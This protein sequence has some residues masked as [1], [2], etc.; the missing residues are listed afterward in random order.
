MAEDIAGTSAWSV[1]K[2]K[3]GPAGQVSLLTYERFERPF[4]ALL[5]SLTI[6]LAN[7]SVTRRSYR[8]RANPPVLHRKELLLDPDDPRQEMFSALTRAL[9]ARGLFQDTR[10]IGTRLGWAARL[11]Q[12][13]VRVIDHRLEDIAPGQPPLV[14]RHR[15]ALSRDGLS[16]PIQALARHG[17]LVPGATLFDY[18]CG[19]GS[20]IEGLVQAGV[21]ASGWDPH[22]A[23]DGAKTPAELVNLGFVLN[24]IENP[25]ERLAVL[26]EA[27]GLARRCLAVAVITQTSAR[28]GSARAFGDGFLTSR[29]TFQKFY[30]QDELRSLLE[31]RLGREAFKVAAGLYFVFQD[32][33]AEQLYLASRQTR[34][35]P[36]AA[37]YV[38]P[39]RDQSRREVLAPALAALWA[40]ILEL[41]R[42]A[43]EDELSIEVV[44]ALRDQDCTLSAA[45]RWA[46]ALDPGAQLE[47][48][49]ARRR[50]DLLVYFA[51]N[52]FNRR[53]DYRQ[54]PPGLQRD[55]KTLFGAYGEAMIQATALLFGLGKPDAVAAACVST[56][57]SGLGALDA[58]GA[59]LFHARLTSRLPPLLR[60][61]VGC[62]GRYHGGLD[63]ADLLKIHARS[64]KLTALFYGD[65]TEPAPRLRR[66]IK[67]DLKSQKILEVDHWDEDQRLVGKAR[68]M[69]DDQPGFAPQARFDAAL[70]GLIGDLPDAVQGAALDALITE[71]GWVR[72][73][74][75]LRPTSC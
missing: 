66:R 40:Q 37:I 67:V 56:A 65:F 38:T 9:E 50:E 69:A 74:Y 20:D 30:A 46:L 47:A 8:T 54:L 7:A 36:S 32:D 12:A 1:A 22:F 25:A 29:G 57:R 42:P 55:V 26:D 27:F 60:V 21:S 59:L 10:S 28:L 44:D 39:R 72:Q 24:V 62:A 68:Y 16:S 18:G 61:L 64:G 19:R 17:L 11:A 70:R 53:R 35:P 31:T 58:E 71:A 5:E 52:I 45:T 34:R 6:N 41:A 48:A 2:L 4:P 43:A 15:A 49:Q 14:H 73:G 75:D 33:L 3:G 13:G 63:E 51:L 23:P